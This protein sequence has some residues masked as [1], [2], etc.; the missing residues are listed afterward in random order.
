MASLHPSHG[1]R[2]VLERE[3]SGPEVGYRVSIYEPAGVVHVTRA[4]FAEDGAVL[5]DAWS[6]DPPAWALAFTDR[7]LKGLPKKHAADRSWPRKITRWRDAR[8]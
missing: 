3:G 7:L 2:V 1:A 5:L 6:S 8:G 4:R